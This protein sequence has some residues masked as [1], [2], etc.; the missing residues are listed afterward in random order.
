MKTSGSHEQQV[1]RGVWQRGGPGLRTFGY[2]PLRSA[3]ALATGATHQRW[4]CA[5]RSWAVGR[6]R[7]W[8]DGGHPT[9][10]RSCRRARGIFNVP[11]FV[12]GGAP[13][14]ADGWR[15]AV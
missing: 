12:T 7:W 2:R 1:S 14:A 3:V 11:G 4:Y 5:D 10:P 15:W 6:S 13:A 9:T 8:S